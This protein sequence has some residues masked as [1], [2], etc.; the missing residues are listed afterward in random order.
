MLTK[1]QQRMMGKGKEERGGRNEWTAIHKEL[2]Y[3]A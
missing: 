2:H 3:N 1:K